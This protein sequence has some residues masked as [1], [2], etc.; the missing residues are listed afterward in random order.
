M[1]DDEINKAIE[2][3]IK[4]GAIRIQG[5]DPVTGEFLYQIT[6]KM[7]HV[8]LDLYDSH[9]NQIY[10]DAM[11]FWERGFVAIDDITSNNPIITLTSKAFD[12]NSYIH[13][14]FQHLSKTNH[15]F[16]QQ[17]GKQDALHLKTFLRHKGFQSLGQRCV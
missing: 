6:E 9:L 17:L 15:F 7:K 11:Y 2:N 16:F 5:I 8:D 13:Q 4:T 1:S 14:L 3:F 10:T 12:Q